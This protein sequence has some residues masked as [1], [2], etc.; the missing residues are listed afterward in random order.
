M[1]H[2]TERV[3][4]EVSGSPISRAADLPH[5]RPSLCL[6][7]LACGFEPGLFLITDFFENN[8]AISLRAI[9]RGAGAHFCSINTGFPGPHF[10]WNK[11]GGMVHL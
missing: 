5:K 2:A 9:L 10:W 4:D 1:T 7:A 3:L 8:R 6:S 11:G